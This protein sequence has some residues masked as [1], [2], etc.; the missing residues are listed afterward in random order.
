[1]MSFIL[2]SA[3]V[4]LLA[5]SSDTATSRYPA[6]VQESS[7]DDALKVFVVPMKGQVGTDIH[8]DLYKKIT[9]QIKESDPDLVIFH[10]NSHDLKNVDADVEYDIME[11]E[12]PNPRDASPPD[13]S[14]L[15]D[16]RIH[17]R[18]EL[19]GIPQICYV[20][21]AYSLASLLALSWEDFY[22]APDADFGGAHRPAMGVWPY[23]K[24]PDQF[25]KYL[26]WT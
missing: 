12:N 22:I 7:S 10:I 25:E 23:R 11:G 17:L 13:L 21:D 16:L 4:A 18:D 26:G 9:P 24:I 5:A 15:R 2:T 3:L 19:D 6:I 8:L 20:E 1:M 14:A